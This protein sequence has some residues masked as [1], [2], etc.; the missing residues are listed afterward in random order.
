MLEKCVACFLILL[1]IHLLLN[2]LLV[3]VIALNLLVSQFLQMLLGLKHKIQMTQFGVLTRISTLDFT[4]AS[5]CTFRTAPAMATLGG[6]M[7]VTRLEVG[8]STARLSLKRLSPTFLIRWLDQ[9]PL[10]SLFS[11]ESALELLALPST[12]TRWQ[13]W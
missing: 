9:S 5:R 8:R 7:Q 13:T 4:T 1:Q 6:E 11:L 2:L 3:F 10:A 12:V